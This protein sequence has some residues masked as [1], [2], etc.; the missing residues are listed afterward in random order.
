MRNMRIHFVAALF[1]FST[2]AMA[3]DIGV[4]LFVD[5]C[6][7]CHSIGEGPRAGPD[8]IAEA[9]RP[10]ADVETAVKRMQ[11]NVGPLDAKQIDALVNL[12]TSSDAAKRIG[13]PAAP[14]ID[15]VKGDANNGR[16]LFF[17]EESFANHGIACAG[18]HSAAGRGGSLAADL[19]HLDDKRIVNAAL[20][21]PF[22]MMKAAYTG[23]AITETEAH[24]LAAFLK[25]PPQSREQRGLVHTLA[26]ALVLLVLGGVAFVRKSSKGK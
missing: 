18:C 3:E 12:L 24:D 22:P 14:P 6:S 19:A 5:S 8:L 26:S 13:T 7:A 15:E 16:R 2:A 17:G 10:K 23:H 20:Q 1:L 9:G 11:D 25:Q 21:T 4:K